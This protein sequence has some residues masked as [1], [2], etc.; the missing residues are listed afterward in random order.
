[1]RSK[2]ETKRKPKRYRDGESSDSELESTRG[3]GPEG[4]SD[5]DS[6]SDFNEED[7]DDDRCSTPE[8][9]K[10]TK[11]SVCGR[12]VTSSDKSLQCDEC[13]EWCHIKAG[14]YLLYFPVSS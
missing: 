3:G 12:N 2:R 8:S 11:C 14:F 5:N 7:D 10:D 6:G 9:Q 13:N 4:G 1:M